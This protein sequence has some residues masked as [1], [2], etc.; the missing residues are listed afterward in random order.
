MRC[1]GT[2]KGTVAVWRQW[3]LAEVMTFVVVHL[4]LRILYCDVTPISL[5]LLIFKNVGQHCLVLLGIK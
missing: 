4:P 2:G 5:G 3:Q 1:N